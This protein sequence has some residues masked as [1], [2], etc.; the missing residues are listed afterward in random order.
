MDDGRDRRPEAMD[1]DSKDTGKGIGA[2]MRRVEDRRFV[3]GRGDFVDDLALPNMAYAHIVRSPHAHARIVRID[4]TA[5]SAA[6]GVV[7]VLTGADVIA[8]KIKGIPCQGFPALPEGAPH[9]RPLRPVL[10]AD[11]VRHVGDGV[12]FI[13]AETLHQAKDAA[14]LLAVD[15]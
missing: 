7:C 1:D 8:G 2:P 15:Y 11:V 4:K 10:A 5:A 9:Y 14:E 6:P 12:A 13:V 3:T